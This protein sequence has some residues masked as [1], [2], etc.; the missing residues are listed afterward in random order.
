MMAALGLGA[1][2]Q[3][4]PAKEP[5]VGEGRGTPPRAAATDYQAHAVAGTVTVAAEFLGHTIPAEQGTLTYTTEDFVGVEAAFFGPPGAHLK[6]S[7]DDFTL[8]INEKKVPS[9]SV[10]VGLVYRSLKD[11]TWSPPETEDTKKSSTGI[12]TGGKPGAGDVPA[13]V[14]MPFPLQRAMEQRVQKAA[15]PEGDR[16]LPEAGVIFFRY[17]GKETSI[18]SMELVYAGPAGTATLALQP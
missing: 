15:M 14:H 16:A 11:P 13:P 12:S 17:H 8:R 2:G 7:V 4:P 9:A 1:Q 18:H 6:L 3:D 5:Q 10:P